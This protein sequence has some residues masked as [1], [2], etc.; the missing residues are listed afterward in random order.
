MISSCKLS[1]QDVSLD[2]LSRIRTIPSVQIVDCLQKIGQQEVIESTDLRFFT[3]EM[4][5]E[6]Y[7]LKGMFLL[8]ELSAS[9]RQANTD[10]DVG[11]DNTEP[12]S[13]PTS[14]SSPAIMSP[15]QTL[16]VASPDD[17]GSGGRSI[18]SKKKPEFVEL[19]T[20]KI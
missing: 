16:G 15:A 6:F 14:S 9:I 3:K 20:C 19:G 10:A 2:S 11:E 7:A 4:T 8:G 1:T 5:A 18:S 12:G 13:I 17:G